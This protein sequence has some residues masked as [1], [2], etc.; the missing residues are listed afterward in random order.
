MI[1]P[2][3]SMSARLASLAIKQT[4]RHRLRSLLTIAGVAVGMFLFSSVETIQESLRRSTE[5]TAS[6]TSLVVYRESRFCPATS[7]L[8]EHYESEIKKIPG[9]SEVIPVQVVVNNC[10]ASLDVIAFRGVP[11]ESLLRYQPGLEV[12]EGSV[13]E[14]QGRTDAALLGENFAM[15]RKLRVGDTFEAVGVRVLVAGIVRTPEGQGNNVAY[16]QLPFLQQA[17]RLGLGTV[18]QFNVRVDSPELLEAVAARIDEYFAADA[19]PTNTRPEKAFFAQTA[20]DMI[21]VIGFTRWIGLASVLT[22]MALVGNALMLVAR[23]RI[24]ESAVLRTLG[25]RS[26]QIAAIVLWEGILLGAAGGAVGSLTATAYFYFNRFTFGSEGLTLALVPDISI[27]AN[28]LILSVILGLIAA[29]WPAVVVARRP[30]V[31]SLRQ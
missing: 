14:W 30:I 7:R 20:G 19:E 21:E 22:V 17:S 24:K 6:D 16:V 3:F 26:R 18:T 4:L 28:G 5:Q 10:G 27:L 23:G 9:V 1:P 11:P 8:P 31:D 2:V 25:F 12:I 29:L 15:R 13:E